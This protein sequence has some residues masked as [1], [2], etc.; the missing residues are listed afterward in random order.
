VV[1]HIVA[2]ALGGSNDPSNLAPACT[3]CNDAKSTDEKRFL[4]K[5]YNLADLMCN[6]AM[7]DWIDRA[8]LILLEERD[9]PHDTLKKV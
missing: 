1:D 2:L 3:D 5:R 4:A 6:P 7:A 9:Q 8:S